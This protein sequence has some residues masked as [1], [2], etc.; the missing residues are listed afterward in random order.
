MSDQVRYCPHGMSRGHRL[1]RGQLEKQFGAPEARQD[2]AI[3]PEG[4]MPK[5]PGDRR[6]HSLG[7]TWLA[8]ELAHEWNGEV[9][10]ADLQLYRRM[11]IGT[12]KPTAEEMTGS[13]TT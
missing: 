12:A 9:V 1:T 4:T 3:L 8:V 6:P 7:Q 11:D 13:H 5:D 10:S 2:I